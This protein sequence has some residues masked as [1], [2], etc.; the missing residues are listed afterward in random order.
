MRRDEFI[1]VKHVADGEYR[2][3]NSNIYSVSSPWSPL[4]RE[5][6]LSAGS[7]EAFREE[8]PHIE[9]FEQ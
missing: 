9:V 4:N 6:I 1:S 8:N 7:L 5:R 3:V 2:V